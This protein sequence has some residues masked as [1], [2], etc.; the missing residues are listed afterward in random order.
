[1]SVSKPNKCWVILNPAS[2]TADHSEYIQQRVAEHGYHLETTEHE[3]HAIA[4]TQT[5]IAHDVDVLAIAGGDGTVHEVLQG[6]NNADALEEVT[7][8][9]L[10]TGTA[11]IFAN[12]LGIKDIEHG[13]DVLEVGERRQIDVGFAGSEPFIVSCIAGLPANVSMATSEELKERFGSVAFVIKGMQEVMAFEG[14][15]TELTSNSNSEE[16]TWTGKALCILIGNVRRFVNKGGQANIEDGLLD[17]VVIKKMPASDT[18][19]EATAH[20]LFGQNTQHVS[21]I[22]T[23]RLEIKNLHS[24]PIEYSLDGE[25]AVHERLTITTCPQVLTTCVGSAYEPS[26]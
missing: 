12:N 16:T 1:M 11:N 24:K 13:F 5:A 2:G 10:P 19:A 15:Q 22:Q 21:H 14:L 26:P 3:D 9:V 4:L 6:L 18:I 25:L 23:R 17:V 7:I 20:R 8:G